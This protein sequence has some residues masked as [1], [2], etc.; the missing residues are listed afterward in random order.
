VGPGPGAGQGRRTGAI[1][2]DKRKGKCADWCNG[3]PFLVIS[4][5]TNSD[6]ETTKLK[7]VRL[8]TDQSNDTLHIVETIDSRAT[9]VFWSWSIL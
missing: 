8:K 3:N 6:L 9:A 1:A 7:I 2:E 5:L 4:S